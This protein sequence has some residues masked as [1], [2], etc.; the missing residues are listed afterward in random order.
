MRHRADDPRAIGGSR[1]A[2]RLEGVGQRRDSLECEPI[3]VG[4]DERASTGLQLLDHLR[5]PARTVV[6]SVQGAQVRRW[7]AA[8]VYGAGERHLPGAWLALEDQ[9]LA[10]LEVSVDDL[11]ALLPEGAGTNYCRRRCMSVSEL[12]LF[13]PDDLWDQLHLHNSACSRASDA[14][15]TLHARGGSA[16]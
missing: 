12:A 7:G 11:T 10:C 16:R 4:Q 14:R 6:I 5:D 8:L 3:E 1:I 2:V 15:S 9:P 13:G